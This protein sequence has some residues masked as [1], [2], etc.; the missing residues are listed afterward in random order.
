MVTQEKKEFSNWTRLNGIPL[1][2]TATLEEARS[3]MME[4]AQ[5]RL[6][7]EGYKFVPEDV[8][9]TF[10]DSTEYGCVVGEWKVVAEHG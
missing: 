3:L 6:E 10:K 2:D 4:N 7:L 8:N 5:E 9:I 1:T